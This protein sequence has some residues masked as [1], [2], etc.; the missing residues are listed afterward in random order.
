MTESISLIKLLLS[1]QNLVVE[2]TAVRMFS[3]QMPSVQNR[4]E[5]ML[6]FVLLYKVVPIYFIV[7]LVLAL[8]KFTDKRNY[9]C[10]DIKNL[11]ESESLQQHIINQGYS[12]SFI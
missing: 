11:K 6:K 5:V 7:P 1:K 4:I 9:V 10:S 8:C 3:V 12:F 2:C